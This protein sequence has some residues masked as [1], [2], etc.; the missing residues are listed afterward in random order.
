VLDPDFSVTIYAAAVF[1]SLIGDDQLSLLDANSV[2]FISRRCEDIVSTGFALDNEFLMELIARISLNGCSRN[3]IFTEKL[4]R[5]AVE[6][7]KHV[8]K[9]GANIKFTSWLYEYI[10][11]SIRYISSFITS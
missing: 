6:S 10:G 2:S 1:N 4:Q 7:F 5:F 9:Q 11:A 8:S 3:H